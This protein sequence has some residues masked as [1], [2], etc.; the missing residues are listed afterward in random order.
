MSTE[1]TAPTHASRPRRPLLAGPALAVALLALCV[2][3]AVAA[4]YAWYDGQD[5]DRA[6][7]GSGAI[8]SVD[9]RDSALQAVGPLAQRVLSYDW[10]TLDT[11]VADAQRVMAPTFRVQYAKAMSGVHQQT[12]T[13]HVRVAATVVG[14]SVVSARPD[15][16][17]ALVFVNQL[18]S[19][20]GTPDRRV[21]QNRVLV[22]LTR[23]GGEWRVSTMDVF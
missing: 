1:T 15:K 19:G 9:A 4:A 17:V 14:S 10:R 18:T 21:D 7:T 12:L 11:D 22:T 3:L 16:V 5:P 20:R 6:S 2:L 8:T 13:N 23:D